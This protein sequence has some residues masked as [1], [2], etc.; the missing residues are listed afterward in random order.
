MIK[1]KF[2]EL[3]K[4]FSVH[5]N[6]FLIFLIINFDTSLEQID[7][8]FLK[9]NTITIYSFKNGKWEKKKSKKDSKVKYKRISIEE[10][11][12]P[13]T[14]IGKISKLIKDKNLFPSKFIIFLQKIEEINYTIL[15]LCENFYVYK[16]VMDKNLNV[17]DKELISLL[18]FFRFK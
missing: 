16:I 11:K 4:E 2:Y 5:D 18:N 15:C 8:N 14:I 13:E 7:F 10:I 1:E 17:I 9:D 6:L 3:K 12:E